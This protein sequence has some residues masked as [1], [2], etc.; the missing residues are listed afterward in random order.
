MRTL[1]DDS[2]DLTGSMLVALP[3]LL[4]PNFRRTILFL[5]RHDRWEGAMGVVLN[6]PTPSLLPEWDPDSPPVLAGVP[7]FEGGP[8]EPRQLLLARL[9]RLAGGGGFES[10]GRGE[11]L[12]PG[13]EMRAFAGYAGWTAGQ[14][15]GEIAGGAWVVLPPLPGSIGN[16]GHP[17]GGSRAVEEGDAGPGALEPSSLGG[18]RRPFPQLRIPWPR[19]Q[20]AAS[21]SVSW[22]PRS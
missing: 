22:R 19:S 14:L 10:I 21:R 5:L 20:Q 12:L 4:D 15:E 16:G 9:I 11:A 1:P 13:G 8:V 2:P 3:S 7:V 6:R 17:G 18:S